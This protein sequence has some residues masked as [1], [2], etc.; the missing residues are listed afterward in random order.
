MTSRATEALRADRDA[1]VEICAGL[2]DADWKAESGCPGWSVQDLVAHLGALFH[3]VVDPAT[4]PDTSGLATE[5]AQDVLVDSRRSWSAG[6]VVDDYVSVSLQALDVLE[7][8]EG[9]SF[10]LP[11]GDLGTYPASVVPNAFAFDHY[12]HIRADLFA[13]RGPLTGTPPQS[14]ELRLNAALDWVEA[15]L[16]QQ[17][18]APVASLA[19]QVQINLTGAARRTISVGSGGVNA[20]VTCDGPSFIRWVT[21]RAAWHDVDVEADGDPGLL[22]IVRQLRV[23]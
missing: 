19:G 8:L 17:N 7:G 18:D 9:E 20:H 3:A 13:P 2:G 1:L 11:L 6:Q 16:P 21:H 12:T 22:T 23:F 10:E 15:A 4:L 5:R 14:D